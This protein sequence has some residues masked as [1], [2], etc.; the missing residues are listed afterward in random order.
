MN[1]RS[2]FLMIALLPLTAAVQG[3]E[4]P[5]TGLAIQ[6]ESAQLQGIGATLNALRI[7]VTDVNTGVTSYYNAVFRFTL[8]PEGEIA[9]ERV[10]QIA[11]SEPLDYAAF[12][13]GT[14]ATQTGDTYI[15]SG[16][17]SL[18]D[19]RLGYGLISVATASSETVS[20]SWSTGPAVGHPEIGGSEVVAQLGDSYAYGIVGGQ[21]G[22]NTDFNNAGFSIGE[23]IGVRQID[24]DTITIALFTESNGTDVAFPLSSLT[25]RRVVEGGQ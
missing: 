1:R 11:L 10:Q 17:A 18:G 15:V 23:V 2:A 24:P 16:P 14:Y 25:L 13:P 5:G 3:E 9:F 8:T 21:V 7:P 6:L 4:I 20:L 19:G 12:Q 22:S